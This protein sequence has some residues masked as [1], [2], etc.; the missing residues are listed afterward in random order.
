MANCIPELYTE[1]LWPDFNYKDL[2][3]AILNYTN[4]QEDSE[5]LV[6]KSI[7][8]KIIFLCVFLLFILKIYF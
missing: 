3:K 8:N 7:N 4:R 1:I 6:I 5:K 2:D